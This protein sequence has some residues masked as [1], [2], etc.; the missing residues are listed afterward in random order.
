VVVDNLNAV[1]VALLEPKT[2]SPLI[3]DASAL[4]ATDYPD[5]AALGAAP[6]GLQGDRAFVARVITPASLETLDWIP[7]CAGM[8][9][10]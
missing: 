1:C 10:F 9:G 4:C 5:S 7:A 6:S 3:I 2:D 8:A